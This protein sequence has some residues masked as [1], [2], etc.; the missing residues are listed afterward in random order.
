MNMVLLDWTRM[1]NSY[2]L[3]GAVLDGGA[4]H[5]VR[6]LLNRFRDAPVRN[7]GWSSYLLDGHARWEVFELVGVVPAAPEPPHLEDV[8]VR[9]LRPCRR[10]APAEQR[11]AILEA[12]RA[13]PG[14]PVFGTV[15]TRTHTA[16]FLPAGQGRRSLATLVVRPGELGFSFTWRR[17]LP[18]PDFRVAVHVPGLDGRQLAVKDHHLLCRAEAATADPEQ[19]RRVL[20]QAVRAMG[21]P[22][23]VRLGLSRPFAVDPAHGPGSCWLMAD[24]FFSFLDP[25]A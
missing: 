19:Q 13:R 1:G 3:A 15:L 16:A 18:H 23:A 8:W 2:C 22:L 6:P 10:S 9:G 20:E 21:D 11:R 25:Q 12:T 24:G 4:V 7:C 17:G 14:E 5:V